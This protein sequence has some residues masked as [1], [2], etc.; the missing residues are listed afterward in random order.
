MHQENMIAAGEYPVPV[1]LEMILQATAEEHK[2]GAESAQAFETAMGLVFD[3]VMNV[4]LLPSY[5]K[6]PAG[7]IYAIGG[8]TSDWTTKTK[9]AWTGVNTDAMR[10]AKVKE[11][12][13]AIPNLPH[14]AGR[15]ARLGDHL[16]AFIAGFEEYAKFLLRLGGKANAGGLFD[17]FAGLPVRRVLRPTR[18]YA[19]LLQRLR[20]HRNMG[21]GIT[22]SA[23]AD[24][25]A[26]FADWEKDAD[27]FW[28]LLRAERAAL[29]ELNVPHFLSPSDGTAIRDAEG[30]E[31]R[32]SAITGLDRARD[33]VRHLD[34]DQIAW[35][36]QIIRQ[37]T[38]M[39]SS[40]AA[41]AT[42]AERVLTDI[43]APPPI[44]FFRAEAERVAAELS[45]RAIRKGAGAAWIGVD[46]LGD[47]EL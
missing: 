13:G 6:S 2:T 9:L 22:W 16:E 24:F 27:P 18:F 32:T 21:D 11:P 35:Q 19:M 10:P 26:R 40:S 7:D 41:S 20:D 8:V 34:A 28:P 23:H 46:W 29:I 4:G 1:D 25:T 47:S 36:V 30:S 3:S 37:N 14:V 15:Y 17:G 39:V 12:A 33:R 31:A 42:P 44:D 43:A 45:E 38:G 5:G